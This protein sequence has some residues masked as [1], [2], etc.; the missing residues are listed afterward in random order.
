RRDIDRLSEIPFATAVF[1]EAQAFKNPNARRTRAARQLDAGFRLALTGTPI[2]NHTGELW[3]LF[4][5]IAPGLLG[6][7]EQFRTRFANPIERGDDERRA[8]LGPLMRPFLLRRLKSQVASE[9]PARTE[10][11]LPIQ[12][13]EAEMTLYNQVRM[14]S[15]TALADPAL[16]S[17]HQRRFQVLAAITRLRQLACNP[18]LYDP[19][20]VLPSAKMTRL[21]TLIGGLKEEGHRTLIFSQFT[22]HLQLARDTLAADGVAY[23]YLDGSTAPA[24]RQSE[25]ERFQA[26]EGDVFFIS[27]KAGGTGLNLT[28]ATYVVHLDPWWNPS[29]EDQ[30]T[31]RAHRIGQR[32]PVTVYRLVSRGTIEESILELHAEKRQLVS[33]LLDG[34]GKAATLTADALVNLIEESGQAF[35]RAAQ[36]EDGPEE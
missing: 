29:V 2:E 36:D 19:D 6:S 20:S 15:L 32:Q 4:S 22:R 3:S 1:D 14:A 5:V 7:W 28:S 30:A 26:G 18:Q 8:S 13:S 31:D 25:V 21:R 34:S 11:V 27:L 17:E 10:I 9:L 12:L 35:Q 24:K 33:S 23:C 16:L